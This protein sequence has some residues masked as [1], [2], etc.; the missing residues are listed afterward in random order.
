MKNK[1]KWIA[2]TERMKWI[3]V[4]ERLPDED[5]EYLVYCTYVNPDTSIDRKGW[6]YQDQTNAEPYNW[7]EL[8]NFN[9][10]N[11]KFYGPGYGNTDRDNEY[12]SVTHWMKLEKP[13]MEN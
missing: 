8:V 13:G 12:D 11:Q 6:Y 4:T 2:V 7:F 10:K 1:M 5:G 9:T 3:A